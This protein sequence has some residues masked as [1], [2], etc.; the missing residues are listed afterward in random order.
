MGVFSPPFLQ[1]YVTALAGS[2][3]FYSVSLPGVQLPSTVLF[4]D[5]FESGDFVAWSSQAP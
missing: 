4:M 5:G 3:G 2:P 1:S